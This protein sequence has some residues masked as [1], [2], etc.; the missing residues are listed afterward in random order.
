VPA[1]LL[2]HGAQHGA[3]CWDKTLERLRA[4]GHEAHAI[5]L[6]GHGDDDT[7]RAEIR[8]ACYQRAVVDYAEEAG[9]RDL[10]LVGH[11]AGGVVLTLAVPPIAARMRMAVF[12]AALVPNPGE[13]IF[14]LLPGE[15]RSRYARE[16]ANDPGFSVRSSFERAREIFFEELDGEEARAAYSRLTPEPFKPF[17][18]AVPNGQFFDLAVPREYILCTRDL[19]VPRERAL[20]SA[21]RLGVAPLSLDSG[22]DA[23]LSHPKELAE[24]LSRI[25]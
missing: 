16:A 8:L 1:F 24:L 3:W 23:M 18:E 25:A 14:D 7:P 15:L 21:R 5:D 10:V 19:A 17:G 22:H 9:L 11:S 6:P 12:L 2:V 4:L 20:E 13:C